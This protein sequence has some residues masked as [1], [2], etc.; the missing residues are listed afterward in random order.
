MIFRLLDH[1]D[2]AKELF[3]LI[4]THFPQGESLS[5]S[6]PVEEEFFLLLEKSNWKNVYF[7]TQNNEVSGKIVST[8]SYKIFN[9][10]KL[11][12]KIAGIG[13]VVTHPEFR[14]QRHSQSIQEKIELQAI[15]E[16]A[17][18]A[19][20]WSDLEDFYK[21]QGYWPSGT[22][23]QW[24]A[25]DIDLQIPLPK[26]WHVLR[27][28][29]FERI[30]KLYNEN[31]GPERDWS[32]YASFLNLPDTFGYECINDKGECIAYCLLG[33][34]RDLRN[35]IHEVGGSFEGILLCIQE[36]SRR[37]ILQRLM[38]AP[39][40]ELEH[41][42]SLALEL[43][44]SRSALGYFKILSFDKVVGLLSQHLPKNICL[45]KTDSS[46]QIEIENK[47]AFESHDPVHLLQ[48]FFGPW[49]PDEMEDLPEHLRLALKDWALP[50]IYFWGMDSV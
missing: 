40:A 34:G 38:L 24:D 3:A 29:H 46:F 8:A 43:D 12:L 32:Q 9:F 2:R 44:S 1:A 13:L 50:Q 39:D 49:R 25:R 18:L 36:A 10:P 16:G 21:G 22:E 20:L 42:L 35:S 19:I 6:I 14:K 30:Q 4:S 45:K 11:N 31:W 47:V 48:M 33:K 7:K 41:K 15:S 26:A 27:I 28:S 23:F 37:H 5:Q 17:T